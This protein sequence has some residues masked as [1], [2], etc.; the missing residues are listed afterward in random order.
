MAN[1]DNEDD[2]NEQPQHGT[3]TARISSIMNSVRHVSVVMCQKVF[4]GFPMALINSEADTSLLGP[5]FYI[6]SQSTECFVGMQG[7][8]RAE[9]RFEN[10]CFGV[11]IA[12]VDLPD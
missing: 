12:A 7:F 4:Q 5:K 10:L 8:S 6:E 11:S 3:I 1:E 2:S 9:S